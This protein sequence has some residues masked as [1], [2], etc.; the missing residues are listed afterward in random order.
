LN[1]H[2]EEVA[3]ATDEESGIA[4]KARGARSFAAAQDDSIGMFFPNL[5]EGPRC[6][7]SVE[8]NIKYEGASG[9]LYENKR[10]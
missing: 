2:S 7:P 1:C 3:A 5:L 8:R 10:S 9:D 4:L 6:L